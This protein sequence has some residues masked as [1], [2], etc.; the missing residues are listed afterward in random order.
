MFFDVEVDV[1]RFDEMHADG[2]IQ[3]Q[4]LVPLRVIDLPAA[5]REA[6]A[7][8][9][10]HTPSPRMFVIRNA[11][12]MPEPAPVERGVQAI[13]ERTI[14]TMIRAMG[15][16]DLYPLDVQV[17]IDGRPLGALRIEADTPL[18]TTFPLPS[19]GE[20]FELRLVAARAVVTWF[21]RRQQMASYVLE[22]IAV[23]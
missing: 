9:F 1:E 17:E 14:S 23:E 4:F 10:S 3:A 18:S 6:Q 2:G 11:R 16:S 19:T 12:F 20:V 22:R 8:G 13:A 15:R 5:M 7:A 21:K